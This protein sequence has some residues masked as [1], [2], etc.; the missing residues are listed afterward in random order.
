VNRLGADHS[1]LDDH[2]Q[3]QAAGSA[4]P[5]VFDQMLGIG[6]IGRSHNLLYLEYPALMEVTELGIA[7]R[8]QTM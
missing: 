8:V 1:V 3:Q 2:F 6:I 5:I 4:K 7:G